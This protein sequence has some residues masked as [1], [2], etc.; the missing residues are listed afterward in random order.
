MQVGQLAPCDY[1]GGADVVCFCEAYLVRRFGIDTLQVGFISGLSALRTT[2][3]H[4]EACVEIRS[5]ELPAAPCVLL[6]ID[7]RQ[8]IVVTQPVGPKHFQLSDRFAQ[9]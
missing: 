7:R 3:K 6:E 4:G 5:I 2:E 8:W 1:A 9:L